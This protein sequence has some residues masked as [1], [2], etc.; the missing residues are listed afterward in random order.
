MYYSHGIA[1]K[2]DSVSV[3]NEPVQDSVGNGGITDSFMPFFHWQLT[4]NESGPGAVSVFNDF[5]EVSYFSVGHGRQALPGSQRR[6]LPPAS[7]QRP[8]QETDLS[9]TPKSIN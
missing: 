7:I 9:A 5:E 8:L 3:V 2:V 6:K 1:F 4:G